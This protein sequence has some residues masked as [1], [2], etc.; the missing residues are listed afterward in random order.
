M[1]RV[2]DIRRKGSV[3]IGI[4]LITLSVTAVAS[5][6]AYVDHNQVA[7]ALPVIVFLGIAV[8]SKIDWT[9]M[10][11]GLVLAYFAGL[12]CLGIYYLHSNYPFWAFVVIIFGLGIN[13]ATLRSH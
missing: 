1:A 12:T 10:T 6:A 3:F 5:L 7:I 8:E 2:D 4:T 9:W 13:K 11:L